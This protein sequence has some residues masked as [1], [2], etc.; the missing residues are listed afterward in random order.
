MREPWMDAEDEADRL[1]DEQDP[2]HTA[3]GIFNGLLL[4]VVLM[5]C[6][7]FLFWVALKVL[8]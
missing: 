7:L 6:A 4:A 1:R 3:R 2:L 8:G 5:G